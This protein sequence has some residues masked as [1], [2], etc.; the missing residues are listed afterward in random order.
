MS[1][2][3]PPVL[4]YLTQL[5]TCS[6]AAV[7]TIRRAISAFV[8]FRLRFLFVVFILHSPVVVVIA[9]MIRIE[10]IRISMPRPSAPGCG[11]KKGSRPLQTKRL[12]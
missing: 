10:T 4:Y 2:F 8:H 11:P 6:L 9:K 1:I 12:A 7:P 3:A 5:N